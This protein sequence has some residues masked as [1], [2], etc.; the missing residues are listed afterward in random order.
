MTGDRDGSRSR[1]DPDHSIGRPPLTGQRFSEKDREQ[2]A[3]RR[4]SRVRSGH[5]VPGT[6]A[7]SSSRFDNTKKVSASQNLNESHN[8]SRRGYEEGAGYR[9]SY[10]RSNSERR[11]SVENVKQAQKYPTNSNH[12]ASGLQSREGGLSGRS[13]EHSRGGP[14]AQS[15]A[16]YN[17]TSKSKTRKEYIDITD[18]SDVSDKNRKV[19]KIDLG[20][21]DQEDI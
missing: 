7:Q 19:H 15:A 1:A 2:S 9:S 13:R 18:C 6:V 10:H 3:E 12:E 17:Q 21:D 5:N 11:Y 14:P 16:T 4:H 8:L 20:Q